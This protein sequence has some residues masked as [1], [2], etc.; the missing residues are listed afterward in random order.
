MPWLLDLQFRIEQNIHNDEGPS[1][2][3]QM[4]LRGIPPQRGRM[5]NLAG[6]NFLFGG[7]YLRSDFD[8]SELLQS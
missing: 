7:G 1:W 2:V 3:F 8:H 5:G 4:T 6:E